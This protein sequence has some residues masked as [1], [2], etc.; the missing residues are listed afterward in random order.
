MYQGFG[1]ILFLAIACTLSIT[2]CSLIQPRF[3]EE[4]HGRLLLWHPFEG[5]EAE[6]L[7][8]ILDNY[9]EL[10][11]KIKII[12]EFFPEENISEQFR[13]Q[14]QSG[15]G[16]DLM[17]S[18]YT[19]LIPLI[20][21]GALAK[22]NDYNLDL[23]IYLPR[24]L[25]QVIYQDQLYGL[26][27]SLN[28]QVLCYNKTKVEQPLS[29]LPETIKEIDAQRQIAQTSNFLATFWGVQI[30]RSTSTRNQEEKRV[31]L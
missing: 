28:T 3:P 23:S 15:L 4:S 22:L 24:S 14:S 27:F 21:D 29:T 11:P 18:S 8:I 25:Q 9:R 19:D 13:Q 1:K 26:P 2:G 16:P 7:D 30:F 17:I 31:D 5:K 10:Y 12:S 6:T 20:R